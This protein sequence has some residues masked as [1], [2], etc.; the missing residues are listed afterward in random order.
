MHSYLQAQWT[1]FDSMVV[2]MKPTG[3]VPLN[4]LAIPV[5]LG[6][7]ISCCGFRRWY[8]LH[9][10]VESFQGECKDGTNGICD[11]KMFLHCSSSSG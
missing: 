2:C 10:F 8:A 9:M 5:Q 11:F 3:M 1:L 4:C 6:R 7:G